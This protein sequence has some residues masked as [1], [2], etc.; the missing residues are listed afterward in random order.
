MPKLDVQVSWQMPLAEAGDVWVLISTQDCAFNDF[1][2]YSR[3]IRGTAEAGATSI[4]LTI[5]QVHAGSYRGTAILDRDQDLLQSLFPGD[6]DAVSLPNQ[7]V[8]IA[9]TGTS[10]AAFVVLVEL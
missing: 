9:A 4:M 1:C 6:G 3:A 10:N 5:D 7:A 8:T 2:D